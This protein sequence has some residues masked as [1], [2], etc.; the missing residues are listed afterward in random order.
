MVHVI[1][2][3][4]VRAYNLELSTKSM[5]LV[6]GMYLLCVNGEQ[7]LPLKWWKCV[8]RLWQWHRQPC[9][10]VGRGNSRRA[11]FNTVCCSLPW[12]GLLFT[13]LGGLKSY[14]PQSLWC[15][16][17]TTTEMFLSLSHVWE[18]AEV[19]TILRAGSHYRSGVFSNALYHSQLHPP[20]HS[21]P[22]LVPCPFSLHPL[23][24]S[25]VALLCL[26]HLPPVFLSNIQLPFKEDPGPPALLHTKNLF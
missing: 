17:Q 7:K 10:G 25:S 3:P 13:S 12:S 4:S 19:L 1:D 5:C 18:R 24:L 21:Q 26:F 22:L 23:H 9:W 16:S 8:G 15:C 2:T 20:W 11:S 6:S 14:K